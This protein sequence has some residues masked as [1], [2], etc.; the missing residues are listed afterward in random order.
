MEEKFFVKG[1]I[2]GLF[3]PAIVAKIR[4]PHHR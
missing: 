4:T 1:A 3:N 2:G